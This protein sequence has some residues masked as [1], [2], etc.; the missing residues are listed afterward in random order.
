MYTDS[1]V[2]FYKNY[3]CG[4][5]MGDDHNDMFDNISDAGHLGDKHHPHHGLFLVLYSD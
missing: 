1:N 4:C 5:H 3:R 2:Y